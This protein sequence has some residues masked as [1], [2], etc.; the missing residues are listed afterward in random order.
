MSIYAL[1]NFLE[2]SMVPIGSTFAG[3]DPA[4]YQNKKMKS[5][6]HKKE[7]QFVDTVVYNHHIEA[8]LR[9]CDH[10]GDGSLNYQEFYEIVKGQRETDMPMPIEFAQFCKNVAKAGS[11]SSLLSSAEEV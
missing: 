10:D 11:S 7:D 1:T 8:I 4:N 9:R 3:L 2:S 6:Y 5:G